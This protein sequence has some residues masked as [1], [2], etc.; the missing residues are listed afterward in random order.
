MI[1]R[2]G[3][4]GPWEDRYGYSRAVRA[5][6]WVLTAGCTATVDGVVQHAGDPYAQALLALTIALD[7]A[8]A[9]GATAEDVVRTRMY[10]VGVDHA[11]AV[12][13]AHGSVFDATRPAATLVTVPGLVHP[14]MLVEIEVEAY[15]P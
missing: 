11:D 10:V 13:R 5:G 1:D 12:G 9:Y 8:S 3:S 7:A 6:P 4:G 15:L 2:L 14:D